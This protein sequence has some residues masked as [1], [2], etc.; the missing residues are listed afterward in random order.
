MDQSQIYGREIGRLACGTRGVIVTVET[1]RDG[2]EQALL[3]YSFR[4][5]A[6]NVGDVIRF[7]L[8]FKPE[9]LE[10]LIA[11]LNLAATRMRASSDATARKSSAAE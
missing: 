5:Q 11:I 10:R 6:P 3:Y 7:A 8:G 4:A 9:T 1:G 2:G